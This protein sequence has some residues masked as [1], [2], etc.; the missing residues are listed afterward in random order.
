MARNGNV[1]SSQTIEGEV[2]T[3]YPSPV[4]PSRGSR[5]RL[6]LGNIRDC[7]REMAKLYTEARNGQIPTAEAGRLVWILQALVGVIRDGELEERI[8]KLEAM[9]MEK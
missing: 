1:K 7:R 9:E 8:A 2:V 4:T 5:G 3:A 6:R